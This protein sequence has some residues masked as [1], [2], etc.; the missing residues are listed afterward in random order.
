MV[1]PDVQRVSIRLARVTF[2]THGAAPMAV[3]SA[4]DRRQGVR[5]ER[6]WPVTNATRC[7]R[8]RD[9]RAASVRDHATFADTEERDATP[10]SITEDDP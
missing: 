9:P 6:R 8:L 3:G 10:D 5:D 7:I 2:A 4:T 1:L